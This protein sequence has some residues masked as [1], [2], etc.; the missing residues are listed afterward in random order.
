MIRIIN[1]QSQIDSFS[2]LYPGCTVIDGNLEIIQLVGITNF[3][4]L[5]Q[6]D[7]IKGSFN[8]SFCEAS[9]LEDLENLSYI[10]KTYRLY[11]YLDTLVTGPI[12]LTNIGGSFIAE[13]GYSI[14]N[15]G[16]LR[17]LE[18]IGNRL[19]V[20]NAQLLD[21]FHGFESLS[22]IGGELKTQ[23][24]FNLH[25]YAGL[26]SLDS[27]GGGLSML[28][29]DI[30][31][32]N[33]L[34]NL[35]KVGGNLFIQ[36]QTILTDLSGL[37]NLRS[38]GGLGLGVN[39]ELENI[40]ALKNL[41][42]AESIGLVQQHKLE[43]LDFS[44]VTN[45]RELSISLCDGIT[46][47]DKI[48]TMVDSAD[49]EISNCDNFNGIIPGNIVLAE[50][51]RISNNDKLL[52]LEGLEQ[53]EEVT[54]NISIGSSSLID[55]LQPFQSLKSVGS[56]LVI[57]YLDNLVNLNGLENL[58]SYGSLKIWS[59]DN[60]ESIEAI[61]NA[62][63]VKNSN[64]IFESTVQI[65]NNPK[66]G[67]C[68]YPNICNHLGSASTLRLIENNA[69]GCA[70]EQE[71]LDECA[72]NFID[73]YYQVYFDINQNGVK[74]MEEPILPQIPIKLDP[75][76]FTTFSGRDR[77]GVSFLENKDYE[78]SIDL[79]YPWANSTPDTVRFLAS[80]TD[81]VSFGIY[82]TENISELVP[83]IYISNTRCNEVAV[84]EVS[85]NNF[86]TTI[87]DGL[88]SIKIDS[89]I[90]SLQFIDLPDVNLSDFLLGWNFEELVP[91][92]VLTK[93]LKFVMPGP[94]DISVGQVLKLR[95]FSL[96]DD[97][98]SNHRTTEFEYDKQILCSY[99]PNDKL[100]SPNREIQVFEPPRELNL[101]LFD[102][103]LTYTVRFQNTGNDVAYDVV[104]R[105]TL[106]ENLDIESFRFLNTSHYEVLDIKIE[107]DRFL[108]FEFKDIFLP[109]STANFDES[110]GYISYQIKAKENLMEETP[111]RNSASIY[112][113]LNPPIVTNTTESVM[114]S[115][116]PTSG[117]QTID[118]QLNVTLSPNPTSGQIFFKGNNLQKAKITVADLTGRIL[119]AE[120]LNGSN[121]IDLP[122][123]VKGM[124]FVKLE[125]EE[126]I[127]VK[128]IIKQ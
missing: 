99:D 5:S 7:S 58:E 25:S 29:D 19:F 3:D 26:E 68:D 121:T 75:I 108:T 87:A 11:R 50:S 93:T 60:L 126:G 9:T 124:L 10:G 90:D 98:L 114:V 84:L 28:S 72:N 76:G 52:S 81:T 111:I 51:I 113:D 14:R 107:D 112:F 20:Q 110:Q 70:T 103:V 21:G 42:K 24:C 101:T 13:D 32:L 37:E 119:L 77:P 41:Q 102:E 59:N 94:P 117:T 97:I 8:C 78:F 1:S 48:P 92:E 127:A 2:I 109:D 71:V 120:K 82:P 116:F 61:R 47:L 64:F 4:G 105:D 67:I 38:V 80:Q 33:G 16:G 57:G 30:T 18:T 39:K 31:D 104:I 44:Q 79:K 63:V 83:S 45:L 106:D 95:T 62:R 46:T 122:S 69:T 56:E 17:N 35:K 96:Y 118:N 91:G 27:I 66:L 22:Y 36:N 23:Q 43:V 123:N 54:K 40:D 100:V 88:L 85:L 65:T 6:I 73:V 53:L 125:T 86:G 12:N 34:S 49:L 15:F 55:N 74:E 115:Q 89:L 128:R